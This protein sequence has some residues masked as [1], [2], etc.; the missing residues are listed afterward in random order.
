MVKTQSIEALVQLLDDP[1]EA[2]FAHVRSKLIEAGN[3]V[4]PIVRNSI[5]I[6]SVSISTFERID[7][8]ISELQFLGVK[9]ELIDWITKPEKDLLRGALIIA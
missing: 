4:L 3:D 1:D 7:L 8:L 2:I 9:N 5:D 6:Q